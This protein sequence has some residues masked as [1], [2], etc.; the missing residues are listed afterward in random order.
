MTNVDLPEAREAC[1]TA[2]Q[3]LLAGGALLIDVREAEEVAACGFAGCAAM[4]IPL[5]QFEARFAEI[6]RDREVILACASGDR[7][8]K[9]TY[10]LMYQGYAKVTNMKHGLARWVARGFPVT[11]NAAAVSSGGCGSGTCC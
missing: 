2:S 4:T 11:G 6:P 10:F 1:P 7:S 8:L 9:A 5:S 3:K